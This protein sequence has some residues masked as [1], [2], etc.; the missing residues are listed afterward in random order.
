MDAILTANDSTQLQELYH[1]YGGMLFGYIFEVVND[2]KTAEHY[3][4]KI[5]TSLSKEIEHQDHQKIT[6]W[7]DVFKYTR[8]QLCH[9][10][11][12]ATESIGKQP[13]IIQDKVLHPSL[14]HLDEEQRKIF[15]DSYYY[16]KTI[17]EISIAL[18]Q[19]E[20]L[21]RKTLR[22]AFII[23]RTGNGN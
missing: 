9:F 16:G 4:L 12:T 21:I 22:E 17:D 5:F 23:I 10:N 7:A 14:V 6:S 18:N 13:E 11:Q 1:N 19:P 2:N 3:L 15:C 20:A 8:N